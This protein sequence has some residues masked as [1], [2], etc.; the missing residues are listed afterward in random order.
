MFKDKK[1]QIL[2]QIIVWALGVIIFIFA[3]PVIS[4]IID[5][6]VGGMGTAT[7]FIVKLFL[8]VVLLVFLAVGFR[9]LS[10]GEGF[11]A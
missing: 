7:A 3:A 9:I 4:D 8:W 10:S 2:P 1:G 5:D 6:S 11:F